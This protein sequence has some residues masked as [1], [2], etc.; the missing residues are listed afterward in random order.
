MVTAA[1]HVGA[2][3]N[4]YQ[5]RE[6]SRASRRT[7]CV[8]HNGRAARASTQA[9]RQHRAQANPAR[10]K[11]TPPSGST[12]NVGAG[13]GVLENADKSGGFLLLGFESGLPLDGRFSRGGTNPSA[14][15]VG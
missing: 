4:P 1:T 3:E 9:C 10:K 15:P 14:Y 7:T 5:R 2:Q 13:Y 8:S 12:G 11:Q 6:L